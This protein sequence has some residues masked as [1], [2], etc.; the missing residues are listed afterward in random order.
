MRNALMG[1]LADP[2]R[3]GRPGK[4]RATK[5]ALW[6]PTANRTG[7]RWR[8]AVAHALNFVPN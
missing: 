4:R 3:R 8:S 7:R 6:A 2:Q 5:R 1:D